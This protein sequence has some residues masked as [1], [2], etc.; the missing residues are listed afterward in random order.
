MRREAG[1]GARWPSAKRSSLSDPLAR[2]ARDVRYEPFAAAGCGDAAPRPERARAPSTPCRECPSSKRAGPPTALLRSPSG[3]PDSRAET[4]YRPHRH[5]WARRQGRPLSAG[6]LFKIGRDARKGVA[7]KSHGVGL[8]DGNRRRDGPDEA[9][10][11]RWRSV[12]VIAKVENVPSGG[13]DGGGSGL[14]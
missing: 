13:G 10:I 2:K 14:A 5:A 12:D 9:G 4:S 3:Y 11:N 1:S 8:P 6:H 7:A